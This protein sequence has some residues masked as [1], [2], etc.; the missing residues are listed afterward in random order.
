LP[1]A[2]E[3]AEAMIPL[4]GSLK[5]S[6]PCALTSTVPP[7]P[8]PAVLDVTLAPPDSAIAPPASKV[9]SPA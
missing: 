2:V 6:G 1:L 3:V 5:L 7:L 4:P 8:A 9:T